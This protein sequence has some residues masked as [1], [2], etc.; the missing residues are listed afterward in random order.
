MSKQ[1]VLEAMLLQVE[2]HM[3]TATDLY[4]NGHYDFCLFVWHLIIEKLLKA[5]VV[6]KEKN[7]LF[8]HKLSN[9]AAHA[10]ITLTDVQISELQEITTFNIE[11]RYDN[12]KSAFYQKATKEYTD[13]WVKICKKYY[14]LL[15]HHVES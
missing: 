2:R 1:K 9:L 6:A 15:M 11:S 4:N 10:G 3:K 5:I 14:E 12:I 7:Y 13:K 8:S